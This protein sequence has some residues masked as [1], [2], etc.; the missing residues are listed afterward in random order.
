MAVVVAIYSTVGLAGRWAA[1][2]EGEG[3]L[4]AAFATGFALVILSIVWGGLRRPGG[5]REIW[6]GVGVVAVCA[7]IAVRMGVSAA[8]RS[9]LFEYGLVAV[10][11][12]E[13]LLERRRGGGGPPAP[14][15]VAVVATALLGWLDEGIQSFV[16][17]RV[18]DLR[19]VGVNALAGLMGV[20]ARAS[21]RAV[22]DGLAPT[23]EPP[24]AAPPPE[25]GP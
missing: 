23:P 11:L 25:V 2:L 20:T 21:I 14:A 4:G 16:P 3:L 15:L 10:L 17:D 6:V 12:Y 19:D 22:R 1:R 9:H 7:M 24:Q 18:Y 5:S 13:A 8:E